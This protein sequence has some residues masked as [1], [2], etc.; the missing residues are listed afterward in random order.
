MARAWPV[1]PAA[2]P[3]A[4]PRRRPRRRR[5]RAG[6]RRRRPPPARRRRGP[7]REEWREGGSV[8][9][10]GSRRGRVSERDPLTRS[11]SWR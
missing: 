11:F 5:A 10:G 6:R 9:M 3:R 7:Q 4:P 2:G 1:I 8:G